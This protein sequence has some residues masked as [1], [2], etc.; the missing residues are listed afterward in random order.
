MPR[1]QMAKIISGAAF[2]PEVEPTF[3]TGGER[4]S[5]ELGK[6]RAPSGQLAV[7]APQ[8]QPEHLGQKNDAS[9]C[10]AHNGE[11]Y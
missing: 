11:S 8:I 3:G 4:T 6:A 1:N 7:A 5:D 9:D 2:H 10:G